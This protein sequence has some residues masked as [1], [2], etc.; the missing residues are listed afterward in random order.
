MLLVG[1]GGALLACWLWVRLLGWFLRL[2][3]ISPSGY[4]RV[5]EPFR[6]VFEL[7]NKAIVPCLWLE[8]LDLSEVP[9]YNAGALTAV[10]MRKSK[11]WRS[12]GAFTRRGEFYLGN[13]EVVTGDPLGVYTM[14]QHYTQSSPIIVLPPRINI[15]HL[16]IA[17]GRR[18][19]RH[20][21][22]LALEQS[23]TPLGLREYMPQDGQR[24]IHWPSSAKQRKL[25]V[26]TFERIAA[27]KWWVILDMDRTWLRGEEDH[28]SIE[29]AVTIA[30]SL[31]ERA[32]REKFA[33][34][35]IMHDIYGERV[36]KPQRNQAHQLRLS[37]ELALA[38]PS[39]VSIQ[40]LLEN[41]S[42]R[43][44][45][46]GTVIVVSANPTDTWLSELIKIRKR[47]ASLTVI[48]PDLGDY[49]SLDGG[50]LP[51][52]DLPLM[53]TNLGA[54]HHLISPNFIARQLS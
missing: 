16:E 3:R 15:D 6:E 21:N 18:A 47:R 52:S 2:E 7:S 26:R 50:P 4:T 45:L 11:R 35:L 36:I 25:M 33:V 20:R 14:T 34:G 8:A 37:R 22:P 10:G 46:T 44:D 48:Q 9:G 51:Q 31:I 23:N 24:R 27:D 43:P 12:N 5:G 42:A 41:V 29:H 53:L 30:M 40:T 49:P 13:Y 1:L 28:S 17:S 38:E 54:M 19:G 39:D 32:T